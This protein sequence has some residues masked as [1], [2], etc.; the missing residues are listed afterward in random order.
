MNQTLPTPYHE[1]AYQ[2]AFELTWREAQFL[3]VLMD[4]SQPGEDDFPV[5][6]PRQYIYTLRKKLKPLGVKI[7]STGKRYYL[8]SAEHKRIVRRA[9]ELNSRS[10]DDAEG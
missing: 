7:V 2:E 8:I 4:Y 6:S 5:P 9:V 10:E 1:T 3:R